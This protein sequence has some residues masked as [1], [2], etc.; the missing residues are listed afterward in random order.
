MG[1][2]LPGWDFGLLIR[3][4][5]GVK[6]LRY[7]EEPSLCTGVFVGEALSWKD[8]RHVSAVLLER[9]L[10]SKTGANLLNYA[11]HIR[12]LFDTPLA[13]S[14]KSKDPTHVPGGERSESSGTG[15]AGWDG[16]VAEW[17]LLVLLLLLLLLLQAAYH[18][19]VIGG[20]K[21]AS[22]KCNEKHL[23]S[24][25]ILLGADDDVRDVAT[26]SK[27]FGTSRASRRHVQDE[28]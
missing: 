28:T 2:P 11:T 19:L 12:T 23:N 18:I 10:N 9:S 5:C 4:N 20:M 16:P 26:I 3:D 8:C 25:S 17:M 24:S 1:L 14:A 22:T 13:E 7:D 6:R 15:P 27:S 21:T